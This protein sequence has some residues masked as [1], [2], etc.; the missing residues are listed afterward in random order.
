[1]RIG[2]RDTSLSPTCQTPSCS[3][4]LLVIDI[5]SAEA[6]YGA[7]ALLDTVQAGPVTMESLPHLYSI[8]AVGTS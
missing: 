8:V 7:G 2:L 1:M 4:M 3:S 5:S 6:S